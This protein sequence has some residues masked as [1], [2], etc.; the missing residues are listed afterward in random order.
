MTQKETAVHL[1]WSKEVAVLETGF[2]EGLICQL[3][4][5]DAT[6]RQ[7]KCKYANVKANRRDERA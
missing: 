2:E 1:P 5:R 6:Q 7:K 3:Y 4:A